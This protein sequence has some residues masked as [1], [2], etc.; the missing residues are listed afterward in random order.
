MMIIIVT[1]K[2]IFFEIL[3]LYRLKSSLTV[4]AVAVVPLAIDVS[5]EA[6]VAL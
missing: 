1:T 5:F 4:A 2:A 6:T 3:I